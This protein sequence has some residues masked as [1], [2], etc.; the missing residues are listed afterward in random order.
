MNQN[1]LVFSFRMTKRRFPSFVLL[2]VSFVLL[3]PAA[4]PFLDGPVSAGQTRAEAGESIVDAYAAGPKL[5]AM[6][7]SVGSGVD[8]TLRFQTNTSLPKYIKANATDY[9][10]EKW[11]VAFEPSDVFKVKIGNPVDV[12]VNVKTEY[13]GT[14][15]YKELQFK[16][17]GDEYESLEG[18]DTGANTNNVT[19]STF[20]AQRHDPVLGFESSE[21]N[22]TVTHKK[23]TAFHFTLT[24]RG[25]GEGVPDVMAHML[26]ARDGWSVKVVPGS[27]LGVTTLESLERR[28]FT[29]NV[30]APSKIPTGAYP[31]EVVVAVGGSGYLKETV[32][33]HITRPDLSIKEVDSDH[34]T[35]FVNTNVKLRAT[36]QNDGGMAENVEVTFYVRDIEGSSIPMGKAII[37]EMSNYNRTT[38]SVEWKTIKII[39][40]RPTENFTIWAE[41]D[42]EGKITETNEGN[43]RGEGTLEVRRTT[44]KK[45]SFAPPMALMLALPL[46]L[47]VL[48]SSLYRKSKK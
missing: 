5:I 22:R 2:L 34:I 9:D 30:T 39:D 16:V 19:L 26:D 8:F 3:V 10:A 20:I 13:G 29:V 27:S 21:E 7:A 45:P 23:E 41:V 47:A 1:D 25:F 28:S 12:T 11:E 4:V 38:V 40:E 31:L 35:A 15:Y 43:N 37:P 42:E 48:H 44:K 17:F 36:I 18:N 46:L 14:D 24:N 33:A 32:I 6:D